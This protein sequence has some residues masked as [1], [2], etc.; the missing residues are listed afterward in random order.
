MHTCHLNLT[1]EK[2]S[3]VAIQRELDI[4]KEKLNQ[5]IVDKVVPSQGQQKIVTEALNMA[6][7]QV[8]NL[9]KEN[10]ALVKECEILRLMEKVSALVLEN[11]MFL[12]GSLFV[13]T[14]IIMFPGCSH[15]S[16]EK[17]GRGKGGI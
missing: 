12:C 13:V 8:R 5:Q 2:S 9:Q 17:F 1:V 7:R 3:K 4:L 16:V 11:C 6:H 14:Q 10:S 15:Y